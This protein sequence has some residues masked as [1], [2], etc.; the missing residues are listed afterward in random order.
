M[1]DIYDSASPGLITPA[2]DGQSVAPSDSQ[3]LVNVSRAIYVG[4]GGDLS[5]ELASGT[6]VTLAAVPAGATLP[7][8]AQ[9][10]HATGTTAG[11]IV[12]LW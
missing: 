4:S 2:I 7:L 5:V 8:R 3:D 6:N 11:A 10:I 1:A 9:K 12:A